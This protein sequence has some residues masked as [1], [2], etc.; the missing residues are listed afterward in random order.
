MNRIA[1]AF[2]SQKAF[3]GF[4]TA[5]DPSL[6]KSEEYIL[7]MARAGADLIEIGI[8]FS[9]PVAEGEV[10]ERADQR[11]LAAGTTTD[12]VFELVSSVRGRTEVPL[13]FLTYINPVFTYGYKRFF[14][15]CR[16]AGIDGIIIPDLPFEERGEI[17][18]IAKMHGVT[19]ITMI[20]PTS[21]ERIQM[22][23]QS[24]EGFIYLV[25]SMGVTGVRSEIVTDL[26]SIVSQIRQASDIP[27]AVGFGIA[28]PEQAK[29]IAAV[30]DGVIVGSRIVSIVEQYGENA[31]IPLH[32]YVK[33][34]KEAVKY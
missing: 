29:E 22:L 34:M 23:A 20:A 2:S 17:A 28:S 9:D 30:A 4:L 21:K 7:A 12:G 33:E 19:L 3:I 14:Q 26:S 15:R 25:S 10:I 31:A 1:K 13:L 27:V 18:G 8:P 11:A 5:G 24:A 32:E 6:E 16:E